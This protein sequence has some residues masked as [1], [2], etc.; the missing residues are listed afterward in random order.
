MLLAMI[1]EQQV[2]HTELWDIVGL[3]RPTN[4]ASLR[5]SRR[6][7]RACVLRGSVGARLFVDRHYE[8]CIMKPRQGRPV[9]PRNDAP[10]HG[11]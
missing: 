3:I 11:S 9:F 2:A 4:S 6:E 7:N 1:H 5:D 8:P 10:G